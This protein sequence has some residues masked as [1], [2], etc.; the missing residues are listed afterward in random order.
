M[1]DT[2]SSQEPGSP[3][4][5]PWPLSSLCTAWVNISSVC[6]SQYLVIAS[7]STRSDNLARSHSVS[8]LA[9]STFQTHTL[10]NLRPC[11]PDFTSFT[12]IHTLGYNHLFEEFNKAGFQV[13]AFDQR[14]FGQT[15]TSLFSSFQYGD[16]SPI[17]S[18]TWP[19]C[20]VALHAPL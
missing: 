20:L 17:C 15:G 2:S 10:P 4:T 9:C 13:S 8:W 7:P 19:T 6:R 5:S 3:S 11:F 16:N 12:E 1:T 14:G 18:L